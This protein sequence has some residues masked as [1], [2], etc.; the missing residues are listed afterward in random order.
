MYHFVDW[1]RSVKACLLA[2][3]LTVLS[4]S[5]GTST[6][7]NTELASRCQVL[8]GLS[9]VEARS[10]SRANPTI[11]FSLE[12]DHKKVS[13][14]HSLVSPAGHALLEA[15]RSVATQ[16]LARQVTS[17]YPG[18]TT[19]QASYSLIITTSLPPSLLHDEM[20]DGLPAHDGNVTQFFSREAFA[21]LSDYDQRICISREGAK[22]PRRKLQPESN[23]FLVR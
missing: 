17:S 20:T 18:T 19:T 7:V 1:A 23:A 16:L 9:G 21:S 12:I 6:L 4:T 14:V 5:S 8:L 3:C 11:L 15:A 22:A 13:T 2:F 10:V